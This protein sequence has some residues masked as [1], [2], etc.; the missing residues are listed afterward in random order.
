[1]ILSAR[2]CGGKDTVRA[3]YGS[4]RFERFMDRRSRYDPQDLFLNPAFVKIASQAEPDRYPGR[5]FH[6]LTSIY[7]IITGGRAL[8]VK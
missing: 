5:S 1:M 8:M 2:L 3:K 7:V 4:E 6:Q